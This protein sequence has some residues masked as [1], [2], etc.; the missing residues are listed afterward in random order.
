MKNLCTVL[1]QLCSQILKMVGTMPFL[2]QYILEV[3]QF[4]IFS[5]ALNPLLTYAVIFFFRIQSFGYY[6]SHQNTIPSTLP[7]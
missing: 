7:K 4:C 1:L 2:R 5:G 6:V 3:F